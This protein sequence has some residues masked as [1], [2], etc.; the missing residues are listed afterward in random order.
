MILLPV[1]LLV[2]VVRVCVCVAL[3]TTYWL[4]VYKCVGM[5]LS[6]TKNQHTMNSNVTIQIRRNLCWGRDEDIEFVCIPMSRAREVIFAI[7]GCRNSR[8][9]GR[10]HAVFVSLFSMCVSLC[11]CLR[12]I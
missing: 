3:R 6:T 7:G 12:C 11:L 1:L 9:I 5:F 10:T 2:Y 4:C 8:P